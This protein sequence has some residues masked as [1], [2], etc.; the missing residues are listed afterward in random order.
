MIVIENCLPAAHD[1]GHEAEVHTKSSGG[2]LFGVDPGVA[3]ASTRRGESNP[4][5]PRNPS[6]Y[7]SWLNWLLHLLPLVVCEAPRL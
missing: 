3:A 6:E 1:K 5:T 4:N 2:S 7:V